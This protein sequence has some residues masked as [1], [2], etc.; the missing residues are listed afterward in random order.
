MSGFVV[1]QRWRPLTG[2]MYEITYISAR[3]HDSNE[4]STATP[5]FLRSS[6]SVELVSILPAVNGSQKSKMATGK[7]EVHVY[8][9]VDMIES[10]FQKAPTMFSR[11]AYSMVGV[12]GIGISKN[13]TAP[14]RTIYRIP[15]KSEFRLF[16]NF[17]ICF[18]KLIIKRLQTTGEKLENCKLTVDQCVYC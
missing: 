2:R 5:T 17:G 6:N 12:C 9:L 15:K 3:T 4:V 16:R 13:R 7:P 18:A 8:Q 14:Y 10:K 11:M 1:N